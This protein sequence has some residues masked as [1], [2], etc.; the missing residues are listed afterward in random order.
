MEILRSQTIAVIKERVW[1]VLK[2][3][4]I[5]KKEKKIAKDPHIAL[6]THAHTFHT[7]SSRTMKMNIVGILFETFQR[8]RAWKNK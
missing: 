4:C 2:A 3:V 8:C 1:P 5:Y 6:N 7:K